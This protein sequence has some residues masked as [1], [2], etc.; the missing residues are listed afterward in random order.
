MTCSA[1][2][3]GAVVLLAAAAVAACCNPA[4]NDPTAAP[5]TTNLSFPY[6][7]V[8]YYTEIAVPLE[9]PLHSAAEF[10]LAMEVDDMR[11]LDPRDAE[12]VRPTFRSKAAPEGDQHGEPSQS[13]DFVNDTG[14]LT[15]RVVGAQEQV[16]QMVEVSIC[17]YDSPGQYTLYKD[18][19]IGGP[20][21]TPYPYSLRRTRVQWT[22]RAAA[23]GTVAAGP[24]WLWVNNGVDLKMTNEVRS[25]VCEPFKPDPF[26]QKMSDPT[27]PTPTPTR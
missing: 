9:A 18:G 21:D 10:A 14:G 25:S 19:H 17:I 15:L 2:K 1:M 12:G 27:T 4:S 20:M 22:N 16:D 7:P 23:D 11:L 8:Q 3:T 13:P 26:V 24:R 5:T 6:P